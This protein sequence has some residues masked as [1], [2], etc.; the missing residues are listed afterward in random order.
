[1][2][3]KPYN[4]K[5]DKPQDKKTTKGMS[6]G[7]LAKWKTLDA[8]QAKNSPPK[9]M[10]QDKKVDE[11]NA[12]KVKAAHEKAETKRGEKREDKAE[13]KKKKKGSR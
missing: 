5:N 12:R 8:K 1:M 3:S 6:K 9:T 13:D 7:E 10:A 11:A 4:E 2:A